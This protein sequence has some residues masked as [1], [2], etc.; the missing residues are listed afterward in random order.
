M[1][2]RRSAT[3]CLTVC[4]PLSVLVLGV[5]VS[6][7][8]VASSTRSTCPAIRGPAIGGPAWSIGMPTPVRLFMFRL[9]LR[10]CQALSH[11]HYSD[12]PGIM[13]RVHVTVLKLG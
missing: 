5:L 11:H 6:K 7:A 4:F 1:A 3:V 12:L 8:M 13:T 2:L 9:W 10:P